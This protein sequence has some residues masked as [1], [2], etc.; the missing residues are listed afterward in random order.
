MPSFS[1][2]PGREAGTQARDAL[3][4]EYAAQGGDGSGHGLGLAIAVVA[5]ADADIVARGLRQ[6]IRQAKPVVEEHAEDVGALSLAAG[7]GRS[8]RPAPR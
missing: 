8:T 4:L 1:R 6:A 7:W 3:L 5:G 2:R